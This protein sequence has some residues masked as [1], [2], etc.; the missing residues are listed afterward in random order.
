M[1]FTTTSFFPLALYQRITD[2]RVSN[3]GLLDKASERR[4]KPES[5]TYD[6]KLT[7]LAADHPARRV[8]AAGSDPIAMGDRFEYLGRI[9]RVL[10][11]EFDGVMAPVDVM[12]E[13]FIIDQLVVEAGGE[14]FLDDALLIGSV[15]RGGLQGAAWEMNDRAT[16]FNA[17]S[18]A[19]LRLDGVKLMLRLDLDSRE[20]GETIEHITR[21]MDDVE[22]MGLP[23]FLETLPVRRGEHGY[24][25]NRS[26]EELV[27]TL[28][29]A[30]ALG[31]TSTNV[32]LKV[33]YV[34]N[35]ERV[36]RATTLPLLLLGGETQNEIQPVLDMFARGMKAGANVR[37]VMA[38]RN[39]LFP[40]N[41]EDP[42]AV[43]H[44]IEAIV[45]DGADAHAAYTRMS[46]ARGKE[47][48]WLLK[49]FSK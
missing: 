22:R 45:H 19:H 20:S 32:W 34:D 14:S 2:V 18:I 39:V 9:L 36:A 30:S 23:I 33:P 28:G 46:D 3:V 25:L 47:L 38:G 37:G 7:L 42:A 29:V 26:V 44:A 13:L 1:T 4:S 8:T 21:V 6:G 24:E 15:N 17:E 41:G 35:F 43:A 10:A 5:L 40:P 16:S 48:D 12:E 27:Q 31:G 11:T 49:L